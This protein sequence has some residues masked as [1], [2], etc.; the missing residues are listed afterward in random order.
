MRVDAFDYSLPPSRIA[1]HPDADRAGCRLMVVNRRDG[2]H[3]DHRFRDLTNLTEPG[4]VI[5]VNR[6]RVIPARLFVRRESGGRVELLALRII[7]DT[8]FDAI[9]SPLRRLRTGE[10]LRGEDGD[11]AF[12]I[13]DKMG[14]RELRL[15]CVSNQP[16]Y[17]VLESFG[18]VPLP[19]YL[20]RPDEAADRTR[21]QTVFARE[22]GSV[23]A[24]TAGLHFDNDLIKRLEQHGVTVCSI[25][26]H[27]GLG[28]FEPLDAAAVEDNTLHSE[29]YRIDRETMEVV[30]RTRRS[31]GRVIAVGTTVV[32]VLETVAAAGG[33]DDSGPAG[34]LHGETDLFIFPGFE[35]RVVDAL[36][37]NFHLPKSSLLLLVCAFLGTEKTLTCYRAAI[38]KQYRF[39]SYGDAMMIR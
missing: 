30:A 28:T 3:N 16:I 22:R 19:P 17:D 6:S 35:F 21:Y 14:D 13:D 20:A 32:R 24:P 12:R 33:F 18:H 4:D 7:S 15:S 5:V 23:A 2:T 27:V 1:K 8:V 38:D 34:D 26:L 39:Y 36:V 29:P 25:V 11:F 31:G 37:T 9:G 10:T